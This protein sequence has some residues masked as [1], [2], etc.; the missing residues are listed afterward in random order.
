M[1]GPVAGE[2]MAG[3]HLDDP[4]R[5]DRRGRLDRAVELSAD[6]GGL[7]ARARARRRQYHRHQAFGADPAHDA[8]ACQD[9]R[10]DL[11]RRRG[12]CRHRPRVDDR[13][14]PD[15][16]SQG[17][18]GL[19]D[20]QHRYRQES[21][22]SRLSHAQ[23]HASRARRQ[24]AGDRVRR[25]RSRLGGRRHQGVRLLQ[26]RPGLH[27]GLPHLCRQED[28]RQSGRRPVERRQ[29]AEIQSRP[30]TTRTKSGR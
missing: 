25:R 4:P 17:R 7:E 26:R 28:L 14:R 6:D 12:E 21:A 23:A 29:G 3:P 30:T 10:R 11:P 20:R 27:R 5:S 19:A 24:G 13:P 2:Y 8:E 1:H 16:S 9:H 18:H 22:A 15:Q